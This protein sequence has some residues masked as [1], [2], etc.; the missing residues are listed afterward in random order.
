MQYHLQRIGAVLCI[1]AFVFC[2]VSHVAS[3]FCVRLIGSIPSTLTCLFLPAFVCLFAA[4][5]CHWSAGKLRGSAHKSARGMRVPTQYLTMLGCVLLF[6]A[7]LI[8]ILE[9]QTTGGATSV[10][11][12]HGQYMYMYKSRVIRP[13]TEHEFMLFPVLV[14]RVLSAWIGAMSVWLVIGIGD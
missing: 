1:V 13:I 12:L 10:A 4:A 5:L 7:I 3:F 6:Y 2:A 14:S 9:Y 11:I 8:F